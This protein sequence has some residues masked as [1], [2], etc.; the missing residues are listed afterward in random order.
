MVSL[1]ARLVGPTL[2]PLLLYGVIALA[3]GAGW[4]ALKTHYYN[5]GWAAA[6]HAVAVKDDRA[7]KEADDAKGNVTAC[8]DGGGR[9]NVVDGVCER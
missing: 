9:W 8:L 2:A 5:K 1:I 7:V 4:L 3:A 6:L